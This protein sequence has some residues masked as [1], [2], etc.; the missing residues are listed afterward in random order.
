MAKGKDWK[1][2]HISRWIAA[3]QSIHYSD[4]TLYNILEQITVTRLLTDLIIAISSVFELLLSVSSPGVA[5]LKIE[6]LSLLRNDLLTI[7]RDYD[8]W[9]LTRKQKTKKYVKF[10]A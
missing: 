2:W 3:G 10:L 5:S 4:E 6:L 8:G 7:I 1:H 9:L